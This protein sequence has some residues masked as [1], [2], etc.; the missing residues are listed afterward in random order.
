VR[1]GKVRTVAV[2]TKALKGRKALRKYLRLVPSGGAPQ[3]PRLLPVDHTVTAKNAEPLR[4]TRAAKQISFVC[5]LAA[6]AAAPSGSP[7]APPL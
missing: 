6:T 1:K 2:A 3:R 5:G 7:F 4:M